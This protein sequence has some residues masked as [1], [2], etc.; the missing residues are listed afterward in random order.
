MTTDF[1]A[2]E[3]VLDFRNTLNCATI[4]S[5]KPG[6]EVSIL[7]Y[8]Q[9]DQDRESVRAIGRRSKDGQTFEVSVQTPSGDETHTWAWWILE[10]ALN[11]HRG[12]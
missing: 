1:N 5:V 6:D 3:H 2:P 10:S 11:V 12:K 4:E 8:L 7:V 9:N